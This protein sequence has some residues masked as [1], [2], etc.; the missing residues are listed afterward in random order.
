MGWRVEFPKMTSSRELPSCWAAMEWEAVGALLKT[1]FTY[2]R[3]GGFLVG[4]EVM[5]RFI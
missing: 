4:H 5:S 3:N 2:F 1:F